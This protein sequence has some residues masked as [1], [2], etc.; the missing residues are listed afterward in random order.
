MFLIVSINKSKNKKVL[1]NVLFAP[2][3]YTIREKTVMLN[4]IVRLLN[5]IFM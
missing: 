3:E 1:K 4:T 2:K 5:D